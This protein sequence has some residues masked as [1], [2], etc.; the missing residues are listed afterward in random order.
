MSAFQGKNGCVLRVGGAEL[1]NARLELKP[2]SLGCRK[3]TNV[4]A[5]KIFNA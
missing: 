1:P 5:R 3:P 2:E 4:V